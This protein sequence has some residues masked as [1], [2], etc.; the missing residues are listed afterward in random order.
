MP[1]GPN[2]ASTFYE[3]II[4]QKSSFLIFHKLWPRVLSIAYFKWNGV[5]N[6]TSLEV[7]LTWTDLGSQFTALFS[8]DHVHAKFFL[9]CI[10]FHCNLVYLPKSLSHFTASHPCNLRSLM[11]REIS[12]V[13][14]SLGNSMTE[15]QGIQTNGSETC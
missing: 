5:L 13:C 12:F 8:K 2:Q 3:D 6:S 14:F 11:D 4:S 7:K 1:R 15:R 10:R 9:W